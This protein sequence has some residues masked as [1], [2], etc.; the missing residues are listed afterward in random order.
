MRELMNPVGETAQDNL[1]AGAFPPAEVTGVMLRA[2]EKETLL[3]RGTVLARSSADGKAVILGTEAEG[4][5]AASGD[6]PA[7][8]AETLEAAWILCD[9]TL[10]GKEDTGTVAYRAGNFNT[11]AL[12]TAEGYAL[13][14]ADRDS[15]RRY[16]IVLNDN[17]Q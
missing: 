14:E 12:I 8:P 17:M 9:D 1:I 16:R 15:L 13:S 7:V 5:K 4:P 3:A 10:V 6:A 11:K 2:V